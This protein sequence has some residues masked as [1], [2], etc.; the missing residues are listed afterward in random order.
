[1]VPLLAL[2]SLSHGSWLDPAGPAVP[3]LT[4]AVA[5]LIIVLTGLSVRTAAAPNGISVHCGMVGWPRRIYRL[6]E[7]ERA[8]VIDLSPSLWRVS[9]GFWWTPRNT[10]FAVRTGPAL[11]LALHRPK[12]DDHR[13]GPHAAVTIIREAKSA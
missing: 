13:T 1:M 8:E 11:V 2:G 4:A 10:Y 3:P 7:I 9:T 6:E 5:V 12:R